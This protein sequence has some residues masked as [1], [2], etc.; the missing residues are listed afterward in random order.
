MRWRQRRVVRLELEQARQERQQ[1]QLEARLSLHRA[2]LLEQVRVLLLE[3]LQPP[4]EAMQRLDKRLLAAQM[5]Q[6]E[7]QQ[8][9][10]E[11]LLEVLGSLQPTASQQLLPRLALPQ[12]SSSP[13]SVR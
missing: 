3:A 10:R 4:A 1:L 11:L 8:E 2:M 9:L 6:V 5:Q 13:S 12:T 7:H